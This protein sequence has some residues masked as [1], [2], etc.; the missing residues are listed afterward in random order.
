MDCSRDTMDREVAN[1][2]M[3]RLDSE[4]YHAPFL[5][6]VDF[7]TKGDSASMARL[8]N[9]SIREIDPHFDQSKAKVF[10][11]DSAPYMVKCGRDLNVFYPDMVHVRCVAHRLHLVCEKAQETFPDVNRLIAT[12]KMVFVKS[13]NRRAA[14][15]D[16]CPGLKLPP[17]PCLTR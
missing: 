13:P 1:V 7:L 6:N 11:S 9:N 8:V 17:E 16:S 12:M 15:K 14:Y 5:V 4:K 10:F 3:G 2:F